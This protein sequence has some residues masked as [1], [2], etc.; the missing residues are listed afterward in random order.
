MYEKKKQKESTVS[1]GDVFRSYWAV[2]RNYKWWLVFIFFGI[3]ISGGAEL[4]VPIFY[5]QFFDILVSSTPSTNTLFS[6]LYF[7]LATNLIG[8]TAFRGT[9]LMVNYSEAWAMA[10]LKKQAFSYMIDHS[11]GFFSNN[12]TGSLV[13][14]V[15]RYSRALE[16]LADSFVFNVIPLLIR[17]VGVI[18]VV[19]FI[20][21]NI[22]LILLGL[23]LVFCAANFFFS[24]WK[25]KYNVERAAADSFTTAVLSDAVTNHNTIQLFTGSASEAVGF[26]NVVDDQAKITRLSWDLDVVVDGVQ[27]LFMICAEFLLFFYAVQFWEKGTITIGS[28]VLIQVYLLGLGGRLWNF[29]RIIR[30]FYEGMADAKEMVEIL[31]LPYEIQDVYDAVTLEV[32]RGKI[33]FKNIKFGFLEGKQVLEKMSVVINAGEKVALVGPSGAGKSTFVRLLLRLYDVQ[34]G[35]ITIDGQDIT[36]VTQESLRRNISLVPQDP[37]LFHRTL[38]EN[39]R[40]G[41]KDAT[42]AEVLEAAKQAHCDEFIQA[43]P[44]RYET[45][46]GERGIKLSGGERQRVAIARAILRNAP[47]LMLDE[48][49]SSLDSHSEYLIQDAL[50]K[51]MEGKTTIVIA[52]RLSTIRK[53]DRILVIEDGKI[54]QEGS[55][56]EL[57]GKEGGLYHKLWNLQAGGFLIEESEDEGSSL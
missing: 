23:V 15:N 47:I 25:L 45:Y 50:D 30:D 14:R 35:M 48:A 40:Y 27:A 18:S 37:I 29:S 19:W 46:V 49:T 56:E 5:K 16:R 6:L 10:D 53:M 31:N 52:H 8:W 7:V 41:R 24:R 9:V 38:M 57:S 26:S 44:Y 4:V 20:N 2:L 55:H 32:P 13:Q 12:F 34:G 22:S 42:D 33:E 43:L 51:L 11:Y 36:Q 39:I 54:I 21:H 17:I 1:G 28:F 3:G